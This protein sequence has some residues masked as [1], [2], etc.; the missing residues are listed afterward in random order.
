MPGGGPPATLG[1]MATTAVAQSSKTNLLASLKRARSSLANIRAEAERG[2]G[3][4][5]IG[6]TA[7]AAGYGVG[8]LHG[9]AERTGKDLTIGDTP[10]TWTAAAGIGMTL[11]GAF[12]STVL[13]DMTANAALGLGAGAVTAE[14][15]LL[16]YKHGAKA[17]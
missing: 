12:G 1:T 10:V 9:W 7:P 2:M 11:L 5:I 13:G 16:G 6:A 15:A 3:R 17:A 4:V 14:A 8:Y